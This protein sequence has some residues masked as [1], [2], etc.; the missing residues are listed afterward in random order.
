M[1]IATS[2]LDSA[3]NS[4]LPFGQPEYQTRKQW[5]Q[6]SPAHAYSAGRGTSPRTVYNRVRLSSAD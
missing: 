3:L 2:K 6:L 5:T 4:A 1:V